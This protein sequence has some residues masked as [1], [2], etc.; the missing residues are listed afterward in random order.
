[1]LPENEPQSVKHALREAFAHKGYWLIH[2]GFFVCGF[3]VM[4]IATHL[5][6][7]LGDKGLEA[8][9]AA[10]ALAYVGVFNIFGS[11][12]WGIM[13]DRFDKR[14]VMTSLY[15]MRTLVIAGFVL[16]PVTNSTATHIWCCYWFLL[17]GY[18]ASDVW[19]GKTNLRPALL[20]HIV[21]VGIFHSS[22]GQFSRR[23]GRW[24]YL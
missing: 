21:W 12:F 2:A 8:S 10:M 5:P 16:L 15:L 22:G 7:Y 17:A 18:S 19:L 23:L 14:Y 11:Y 9:S 24:S 13:G 4:F 3:H 1:M 6:S 20:I